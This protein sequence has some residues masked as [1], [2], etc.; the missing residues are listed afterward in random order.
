VNG[1]IYAIG[2][3]TG[4]EVELSI[5]EE[6]T[7]EGWPFSISPQLKLPTGIVKA[8]MKSGLSS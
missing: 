7:P 5:V 4:V 2:G 8:K 1:K 3:R 6:Y